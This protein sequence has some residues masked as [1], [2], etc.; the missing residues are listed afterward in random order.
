MRIGRSKA[1][2]L[3]VTLLAL[4]VVL[5][6][7]GNG[8]AVNG[9]KVVRGVDVVDFT[10][11]D[12]YDGFVAPK[13]VNGGIS[14]LLVDF[15]VDEIPVPGGLYNSHQSF[16]G[17]EGI[18]FDYGSCMFHNMDTFRD[19]TENPNS[20]GV[21][22]STDAPS[23]E[24]LAEWFKGEL[25]GRGWTITEYEVKEV[26]AETVLKAEKGNASLEMLAY[27]GGNGPGYN[28]TDEI[29]ENWDFVVFAL[30]VDLK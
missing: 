21:N 29:A 9:S 11:G 2:T 4:T 17:A 30:L 5:A 6:G 22:I 14:A 24:E 28:R 15:P 8:V 20:Y 16:N 1:L 12:V 23:D 18:R 7:C 10:S 27:V 26:A 19:D 13:L 25:E 3:I